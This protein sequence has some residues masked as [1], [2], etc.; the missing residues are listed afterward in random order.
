MPGGFS[1]P[2][3]SLEAEMDIL[4]CLIK[5]ILLSFLICCCAA[6][7]VLHDSF[8]IENRYIYLNYPR[9][10]IPFVFALVFTVHTVCFCLEMLGLFFSN[11]FRR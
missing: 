1:S 2:F 8:S 9:W 3:I 5:L 4:V 6:G 11:L 10:K 7:A